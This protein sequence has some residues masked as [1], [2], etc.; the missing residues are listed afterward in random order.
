MLLLRYRA[1]VLLIV[2]I[3][4]F[5]VLSG[6]NAPRDHLATFNE[7]FRAADYESSATFAQ[8]KIRKRKNPHGDDLLWVLQLGTVERVRKNYVQ[9][10]ECFDK[11]EEMLKFYD[12]QSTVL[13]GI[14]STITNDNSIPYRG[15]EYDAIMVNTYKALNFMAEGKYQLARI[16]FNRALDRQRRAKE[17]FSNEINKLNSK[18][19]KGQSKNRFAQQNV[20]SSKIQQ[21]IAQ[22]YPNLS[23]FEAYP[24]FVNP[25]TTYLAGV[26]FNLSGDSAK[27]HDLFKESYGMVGSNSYIADDLTITDNILSGKKRINDTVWIFFE[28][29]MGPVREEFRIDI[30]LF[31]ATNKIKYIGIALPKLALRDQAYPYLTV[32]SDNIEYKTSMLA[33]MDRIIQTEFN[34]DYDAILTRTIISAG[35]KALAQ[36]ALEEEGSSEAAIASIA[37]AVFNYTQTAAD[38]RTWTSLPKNFQIARFKKPSDG[39]L[40]ITPPGSESINIDIPNCTNAIVYVKIPNKNIVPIYEVMTF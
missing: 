23:N 17:N 28:N 19:Q 12:H 2:L 14:G 5:P 16:E 9:S 35:A 20:E 30:P 25:F 34:K 18:L 8:K 29:G 7:H 6:C 13:D 40:V 31:V 39:K 15:E 3:L 24:D 33:N 1:G 4:I 26:Y 27:A 11:A 32:Q 21:L 37:M 10:S 38:V 36:Y 22:Q